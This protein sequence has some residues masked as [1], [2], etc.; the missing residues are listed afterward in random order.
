M[1]R[2]DIHKN[3]AKTHLPVDDFMQV[4]NNAPL[5]SIDLI[6]EDAA[7]R[8]LLGLR[9]NAPARG[10]WFVPGGR[11]YKN[12]RLTE[13]LNRVSQAELGKSFGL[14]DCRFI[15][16]YEHFYADNSFS[17]EFG[18]HYVVLAFSQKVDYL[19]SLPDKQHCGYRWLLPAEILGDPNVHSHTRDYFLP[20]K[21]VR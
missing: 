18:T 17:D 11:V 4:I 21:G 15:G 5:I 3:E 9:K 1:T 8:F 6:I 10:C 20:S 13:A 2:N 16:I 19:E 12:E 7:G 14:D